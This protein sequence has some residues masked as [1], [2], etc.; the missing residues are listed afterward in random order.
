MLIICLLPLLSK[1]FP[2]P[3]NIIFYRIHFMDVRL[4]VSFQNLRH[5]PKPVLLKDVELTPLS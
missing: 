3:I 5:P 2:S 4:K 1:Y